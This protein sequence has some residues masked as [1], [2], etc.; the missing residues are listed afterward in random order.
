MED[1]RAATEKFAD[2]LRTL[3]TSVGNPSFRK[4]AGRSGRISHTTLHEAAAGT[5]FPSWETTREFVRACEADEAEWRRLWEDAQRQD[6]V[7][8]TT[9]DNAS[10]AVD[11][12]TFSDVDAPA[13]SGAVVPGVATSSK[14]APTVQRTP[15]RRWIAAM[16]ASVVTGLAAVGVIIRGRGDDPVAT[17]SPSGS[18]S[19]SLI[20]GDASRF[21]GDITFPDGA[22]VKVNQHFDKV[23]ALAN[24]GQ[25]AWHK[26]FLAPINPTGEGGCTV[27]DRVQIGD[28]PPGE[29]VMITVPVV[30]PSNPGKCMVSWKMVDEQGQPY[31]P[32]RRPVYFLVNVTV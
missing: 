3:R 8:S 21:V 5:R 20:P 31:F 29:Q 13:V 22:K 15:R 30:A 32:S 19:D 18:F 28:T 26:R 27:P 7:E 9:E 24:V 11:I 16:A 12:R 10:G 23:W 2:Q 25:V 14:V 17:P 6:E 1:Q 4:M